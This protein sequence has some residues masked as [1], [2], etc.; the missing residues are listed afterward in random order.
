MSSSRDEM[1]IQELEEIILEVPEQVIGVF[2]DLILAKQMR[3]QEGTIKQLCTIHDRVK[4]AL[5]HFGV[6]TNIHA[7]QSEVIEEEMRRRRPPGFQTK[8]RREEMLH[9]QNILDTVHEFIQVSIRRET[10]VDEVGDWLFDVQTTL[11]S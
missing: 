7:T 1:Q 4:A 11:L 6:N 2:E 9:K 8:A 5:A 3:A 10:L